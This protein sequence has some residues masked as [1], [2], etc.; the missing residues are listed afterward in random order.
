MPG[1]VVGGPFIG[2]QSTECVAR[3]SKSSGVQRLQSNC[4]PLDG[5][6]GA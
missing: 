2:V 4:C 6:F 5:G 1:V 3:G